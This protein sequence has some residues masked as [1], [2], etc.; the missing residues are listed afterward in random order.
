M[1]SFVIEGGYPI[2]GTIVPGGNK[3]AALPMLAACLLTDEPVT[4]HNLP[5]IGD[6]A[7]MGELLADVGVSVRKLD[8]HTWR[9]HAEN[10]RAR[11][12]FYPGCHRMEPYRSFYPHAHLLLPVTERL[13]QAVMTLPT[14]TAIGTE[15]V[16]RVCQLIR[17]VVANGREVCDRLSREDRQ[18]HK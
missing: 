8:A 5:D 1:D 11:R 12:Y 13:S 2:S 15:H 9:L 16:L 10:V 3:N 4:L 14:G 7:T 6:V 17:F 18:R